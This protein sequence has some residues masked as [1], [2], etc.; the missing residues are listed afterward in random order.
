MRARRASELDQRADDGCQLAAL[1]WTA[2][3]EGGFASEVAADLR[4]DLQVLV[5]VPVGA[6][7]HLEVTRVDAGPGALDVAEPIGTDDGVPLVSQVHD[8]LRVRAVPR[9]GAAGGVGVRAD[10]GL[11]D[12]CEPRAP[13]VPGA[14]LEDEGECAV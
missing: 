8:A 12:L 1:A 6:E 13:V 11:E 9:P 3:A 10:H 14:E 7:G 2:G 4:T 5:G